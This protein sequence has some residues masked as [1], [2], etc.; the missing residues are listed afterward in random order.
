MGSFD[1]API[2]N[3]R[4]SIRHAFRSGRQGIYSLVVP[5]YFENATGVA[6]EQIV[7]PPF[8]NHLLQGFLASGTE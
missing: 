6:G 5:D 4:P 1:S 3:R 2:I 7:S 8:R